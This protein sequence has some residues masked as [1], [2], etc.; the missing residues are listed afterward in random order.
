[1]LNFVIVIVFFNASLALNNMEKAKNCF[2]CQAHS[3][4][5]TCLM[6]EPPCSTHLE[7]MSVKNDY[8]EL[9][10]KI[11]TQYHSNTSKQ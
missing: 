9:M 3:K 8:K 7:K 10:Y 1:M 5:K 2:V 4:A 6:S 11:S